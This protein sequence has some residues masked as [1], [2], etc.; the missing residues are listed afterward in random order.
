M[1][2]SKLSQRDHVHQLLCF[3]TSVLWIVLNIPDTQHIWRVHKASWSPA[4]GHQWQGHEWLVICLQSSSCWH[5]TVRGSSWA[6][7]KESE[8]RQIVLQN[9]I[10]SEGVDEM[11]ELKEEGGWATNKTPNS[12][13]FQETE[14]LMQWLVT[15]VTAVSSLNTCGML[16]A[17]LHLKATNWIPDIAVAQSY[18]ASYCPRAGGSGLP[19]HSLNCEIKDKCVFPSS[20]WNPLET[21]PLTQ[22]INIPG[23]LER[24][25]ATVALPFSKKK[26]NQNP[27]L[28]LYSIK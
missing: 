7:H 10:S 17:I 2:Q 25:C 18:K 20:F 6:Q 19:S 16:H 24:S 12:P 3:W 8:R 27:E 13:V 9:L 15:V 4:P 5:N 26:P 11:G 23:L 22:V 21:F 1:W 28:L 14:W